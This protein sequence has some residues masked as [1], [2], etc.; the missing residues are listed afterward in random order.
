MQG[1]NAQRMGYKKTTFVED[2]DAAGA[3]DKDNGRGARYEGQFFKTKV[4]M[5]WEKGLCTRGYGCKYAHGGTEINIMPDLTN[6]S[7]CPAIS[8]DG[9]CNRPN[10]TFAHSLENLRATQKFYKTSMCSFSRFGRCRM[11]SECRH[12]HD[13]SELRPMPDGEVAPVQV[14]SG[15]REM[16]RAGRS[17]GR[18]ERARHAVKG[19]KEEDENDDLGSLP[20][21][22]R[23][24]TTPAM[25][26]GWGTSNCSPG[27]QPRMRSMDLPST[28]KSWA[29]LSKSDDE[30]E[31]LD[32]AFGADMWVRMQTDPVKRGPA[33]QSNQGYGGHGIPQSGFGRSMYE[34]DGPTEQVAVGIGTVKEDRVTTTFSRFGRRLTPSPQVMVPVPVAMPAH[35]LMDVSSGNSVEAITFVRV[36]SSCISLSAPSAWSGPS[37]H[38]AVHIA[39]K[40]Y[41]EKVLELLEGASSEEIQV[42]READKSQA[43]LKTETRQTKS[44]FSSL[45]GLPSGLGRSYPKEGVSLGPKVPPSSGEEDE[46]SSDAGA[47]GFG[48]PRRIYGQEKSKKKTKGSATRASAGP[49][50]LELVRTMFAGEV[51]KNSGGGGYQTKDHG[52]GI[53]DG[54]GSG[55][56]TDSDD[57][58]NLLK[59]SKKAFKNIHKIKRSIKSRPGRLIKRWETRVREDL[60]VVEG[61]PWT[62]KD[63]L[64]QQPWGKRRGLYRGGYQ[65]IVVY[66]LLRQNKPDQ[67]CAQLVQNLKS[68]LQCALADGS[69]DQV[70]LLR[71][72]PD[73]VGNINFA[74]DAGEMSVILRYTM[75]LRELKM[76]AAGK[77][78]QLSEEDSYEAVGANGEGGGGGRNTAFLR[79]RKWLDVR[80][81]QFQ[82][83]SSG[84]RHDAAVTSSTMAFRSEVRASAPL[85]GDL[86][87]VSLSG[88]ARAF[89]I[90]LERLDK[91]GGYSLNPFHD[92]EESSR[93]ALPV[94][95][96]RVAV[97]KNAGAI[98]PSRYLCP[99]RRA[100]FSGL[101]KLK[102]EENIW[103]LPLPTA[104]HRMGD[105]NACDIAQLVHKG[106]PDKGFR[107]KLQFRAW[108]AEVD[109]DCGI[110]AA[111]LD[112]RRHLW[113]L[114]RTVLTV[115]KSTLKVL[116]KL[117]GYFVFAFSTRRKLLCLFQHMCT[118]MESVKPGL[119]VRFPLHMLDEMR[120]AALRLPLS[121]HDMRRPI[122]SDLGYRCYLIR[123]LLRLAEVRGSHVR[124]TGLTSDKDIDRLI[125]H[126]G[127]VDAL[128][129]SLDWQVVLND[130][131]V[132]VGALGKGRSSS[133]QLNGIMRGM[134]GYLI[135]T[136][137]TLR[138]VWV[139]TKSN[140]ADAPSRF[141]P[142]AA[143]A[144]IPTWAL[145]AFAPAAN[146][147]LNMD[148]HSTPPSKQRNSARGSEIF[149]GSGRITAAMKAAGVSMH[150]PYDLL[151]GVGWNA[152]R[153]NIDNLFKSK[154]G[155]KDGGALRGKSAKA[156][157]AYPQLFCDAFARRWQ[158]GSAKVAARS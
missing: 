9:H 107:D 153:P 88:G 59:G 64:K 99:A 81:K 113:R 126:C 141:E 109:G 103:P 92:L 12:A 97:P 6:T 130:S 63:W 136:D 129:T 124:L 134:L 47:E 151:Y 58:D 131:Q 68:K 53:S 111:P 98:D 33:H 100:V 8:K 128:A 32:S 83:Y 117:M 29:D 80:F 133:F 154:L 22:E 4:C 62:V 101:E 19:R 79:F 82:V 142:L 118:F 150:D 44:P 48:R 86:S 137:T 3:L 78:P 7:L 35:P 72:L 147:D 138:L 69:W 31:D 2:P 14:P 51:Q 30:D 95:P 25:M 70:G 34:F 49:T 120:S 143:P 149:A 56:D 54:S 42:V 116:Q 105:S 156:A 139:G 27:V 125:P 77:M 18:A 21:W 13:L 146:N 96:S 20:T 102:L 148:N 152:M 5:F 144:P 38:V 145:P 108:G 39:V 17:G 61:Q 45:Q 23:T 52:G 1:R 37:D 50:L 65:D 91:C 106:A 155:H 85:D 43:L 122:N 110:V 73:P 93:T 132:C 90:A 112:I 114:A 119:V 15:R 71:G 89:D 123:A 41:Y 66:E 94:V 140:P 57:P 121:F 40:V 36:A 87:G 135:C 46:E 28:T 60:G 26:G 74:G 104:C 11:A 55:S 10:C 16:G 115:G 24:E 84:Y 127:D 67:A 76:K 157:A 158:A 75:P